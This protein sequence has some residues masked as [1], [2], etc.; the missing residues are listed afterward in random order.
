MRRR[1]TMSSCLAVRLPGDEGA[2]STLIGRAAERKKAGLCQPAPDTS[3]VHHMY[4]EAIQLVLFLRQGFLKRVLR[5]EPCQ[6][7]WVPLAAPTCT[8][9]L[10]SYLLGH[11]GFDIVVQIAAHGESTDNTNHAGS[12]EL[13]RQFL[14]RNMATYQ[15]KLYL[16]REACL[17]LEEKK[18]VCGMMLCACENTER[19]C[20][21]KY[22]GE[23]IGILSIAYCDADCTTRSLASWACFTR[24]KKWIILQEAV[25]DW[26]GSEQV[27]QKLFDPL[28]A[29]ATST[30]DALCF[31]NFCSLV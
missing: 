4:R 7:L 11:P 19:S 6:K 31:A 1:E 24:E 15:S 14:Y 3:S 26:T 22:L 8:C 23:K 10:S 5:F 30:L 29:S 13:D 2:W 16:S 27:F 18:V 17:H 12:D 21:R 28:R 9:A 25:I 20:S